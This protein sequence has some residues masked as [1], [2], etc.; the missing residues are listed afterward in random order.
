VRRIFNLMKEV[1]LNIGV[2]KTDTHERISV[3]AL[4]DSGVTEM[5]MNKEFVAK[6]GFKLLKLERPIQV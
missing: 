4:L 2:E 5:L 3:K 6:R 1:W